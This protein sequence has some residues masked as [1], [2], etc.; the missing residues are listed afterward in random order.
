MKA[1]DNSKKLDGL[2]RSAIGR[3]SL[4]FDFQPWQRDHQG[5]IDEFKSQAVAGS[6]SGA[7]APGLARRIMIARLSK[8]VVAAMILVAVLIGVSRFT[9]SFDG[10][11][12]AYAKV[13]EAVRNVPWM[14][15]RYTGYDLDK[16]G[17]KVHAEGE[18]DSEI[19]YS[20]NAQIVIQRFFF[21]GSII[22]YDYA[23]QQVHTYNPHSK[24]IVLSALSDN[25]LPVQADSPWS[26]VQ[27]N[28]R[29]MTPC[30]GEVTRRAG[31]YHGQDVEVF[32]I[33]ATRPGMAAIC[34]KI[35]A[36]RT[37]FLPLAEERTYIATDTGKT[38]TVETGTFDYPEHGP[39]DIYALGL[40]RDTPTVNSL[41][42]PPW[43]EISSAYESHRS[44]VP[45]ERYIAVVTRQMHI[46]GDPVDTVDVFYVDG[47]H[48]REE[49]HFVFHTGFIG[50]QWQQQAGEVG[51][52]F[53]SIWKWS[54]AYKA[55]GDISVRLLEENHYYES[56]R[57]QNGSWS[58]T[59]RTLGDRE[60]TRDDFWNMCPVF[61]LG[62]PDIWGEAEVIQDD[63]A[64]ENHLIRLEVQRGVFY[65][66]PDRDYL[67]QRRIIH[68]DD[69]TE[70]VT[71]FGQTD[72]GRWYPRKV[73]DGGLTHTIYLE[74]HPE[75]PEGIFDPNRL[76]RAAR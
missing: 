1:D 69:R 39:T 73:K 54:R 47:L 14:H 5:Q 2:I 30:G 11:T 17:N 59:E 7:S 3:G 33:A 43:W 36:D 10:T 51:T 75:L 72:D 52:T 27:R 70:D 46:G 63:Y 19:W 21:S 38:Q 71:E 56:R 4:R 9:G 25:R 13:T 41:P 66:N 68:P 23:K 22:Y 53:D 60:L 49:R 28:I 37:T 8:L 18:L 64:R 15:I 12:A 76:P 57:G 24:R 58:A 26:W 42:L 35:F 48:Y 29:A 6:D 67:C 74:T 45:A 50:E 34:G 62:W 32:E 55:Y 20:F 31:Q 16:Q 40:S 61:K 65:L 44:K